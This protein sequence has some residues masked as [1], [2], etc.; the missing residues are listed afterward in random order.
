LD[1]P[2]PEQLDALKPQLRDLAAMNREIG[3][4]GGIQNHSGAS[5]VGCAV[6]D[7][8][9]LIRDLDPAALGTCFDIA[10]ATL[11]G[12]LSWQLESRLMEPWFVCVY[13][14]DFAWERENNG[15][16][17]QWGPLG[18]GAVRREFIQ[19]L[20]KSSYRG[21]ISLHVEYISGDSPKEIAQMKADQVVLREWLG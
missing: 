13:V 5:Y 10:H 11:E 4:R 16:I 8:F 1:K 7:I 19:W 3:V 2:I 12:G 18:R 6:W 20:K 15:F 21:P 9:E 17:P 14:K